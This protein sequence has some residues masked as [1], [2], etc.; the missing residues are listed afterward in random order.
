MGGAWHHILVRL[1]R[2]SQASSPETEGQMGCFL[3]GGRKA[4]WDNSRKMV[5]IAKGMTRMGSE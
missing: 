4:W 2:P 5:S 3:A 1:A